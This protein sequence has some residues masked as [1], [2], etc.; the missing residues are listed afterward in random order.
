MSYLEHRKMIL[1]FRN[2]CSNPKS[3]PGGCPQGTL[4]GVILYILYINLIGF[5]GEI[6]LQINENIINYWNHIDSFLDLFP[7]GNLLPTSMN[8]AKFM[9][10]ATIQESIALQTEEVK[11]IDAERQQVIHKTKQDLE[12]LF[13]SPIYCKFTR[14]ST[15]SFFSLSINA[16]LIMS[17]FTRAHW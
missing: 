17:L 3:L 5:P 11:K 12:D 2:C 15:S 14:N 13:D 10:D 8:S 1:R 7:T 16:R 9:D 6:T 4:I